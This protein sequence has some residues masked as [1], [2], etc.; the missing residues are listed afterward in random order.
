LEPP[1]P[2]LTDGQVLLRPAD[3]RDIDAIDRGISD[4]DVVRWIGQPT[5]SARD[6]LELNRSR[7]LGG[8]GPT[9]AIC[10]PDDSCIGHVWLNH[11][12]G[13]RWSIGYWLLPGARGRG[14]ATR[15]VRLVSDWAF[16]DLGLSEIR[17][18]TERAN[19]RSQ[20]VALRSGFQRDG[21]I[22]SILDADGQRVELADFSLKRKRSG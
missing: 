10:R 19:A 6:V 18:V 21:P 7:W 9:F 3:E 17:L 20:G 5:M 14:F 16:G 1:D 8:T 2:A 13:D 4:P 12:G 22:R 15:A 11:H